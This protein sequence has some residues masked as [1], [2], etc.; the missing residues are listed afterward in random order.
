[1]F[2][3]QDQILIGT[4]L[5]GSSIVKPPEGKNCYLSMRDKNS[6]WLQYKMEA[7]TNYFK[8]PKIHRYGNSFRCNSVCCPRLTELRKALYRDNERFISHEI[9]D[10]MQSIGLSIWY[11]DGGGK[12][13]RGRKNVYLNTTKFGEEGSK[14]I[15]EYFQAIFSPKWG[16][17]SINRNGDNR[18]RVLLDVK[19]SLKFLSIIASDLPT[20]M[21]HKM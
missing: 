6:K 10:P 1:M 11:I 7:M 3:W 14:I 17:C 21:L 19:A 8:S 2:S 4:V 5:S 13:G 12:T 16:G 20:F 18:W 15:C 9:L